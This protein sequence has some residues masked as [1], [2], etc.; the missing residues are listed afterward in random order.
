[1]KNTF[2]HEGFIYEIVL[3]GLIYKKKTYTCEELLE[4]EN[5]EAL[6]ELVEHAWTGPE[7]QRDESEFNRNGIFVLVYGQENQEPTEP[8]AKA[9]K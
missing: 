4:Q 5:R 7:G 3:P 2:S 6:E 8:P 9:K 1:M